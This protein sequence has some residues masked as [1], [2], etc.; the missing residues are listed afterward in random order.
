MPNERELSNLLTLP[1]SLEASIVVEIPNFRIRKW[2]PC[3]SRICQKVEDWLRLF[4]RR[5]TPKSEHCVSSADRHWEKT[6]LIVCG[7]RVWHSRKTRKREREKPSCHFCH[8]EAEA[9]A[10]DRRT[11]IKKRPDCQLVILSQTVMDG[12]EESRSRCACWGRRGWFFWKGAVCGGLEDG[13]KEGEW[14][15]GFKVLTV[16]VKK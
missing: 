1:I 6:I 11:E 12:M 5:L 8:A 9:N 3:F 14:V 2:K 13:I 4:F 10:R 15:D 16:S 7:F